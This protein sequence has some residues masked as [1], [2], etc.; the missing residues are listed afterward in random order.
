[1]QFP[2]PKLEDSASEIQLDI[3]QLAKP[4]SLEPSNLLEQ[5]LNAIFKETGGGTAA[6]DVDELPTITFTEEQL[7]CGELV[8][9]SQIPENNDKKF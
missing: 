3:H 8:S 5:E 9:L 1:M 4:G 2:L 6:K 7:R